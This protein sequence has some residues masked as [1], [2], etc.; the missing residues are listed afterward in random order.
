M[1]IEY[2]QYLTTIS[3]FIPLVF[4]IFVYKKMDSRLKLLFFYVCFSSAAS[5]ISQLIS[6]ADT[7]TMPEAHFYV[8]FE[9]I[10]LV[11]FYQ[12]YLTGYINKKY[13]WLIISGFFLLSIL[14]AL[15]FQGIDEYPN[16]PRGVESMV[17]VVFSVLYFHKVMVEAKI[18]NLAKEPMIWINTGM[19][20]YFSGD[21]FFH[22]SFPVVLDN[23]VDFA[24]RIVYFF[25]GMNILFYLMLTI[26]FYKQK[27]LAEQ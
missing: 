1:L 23:S 9:F 24:R 4:G 15:Y 19:L 3:P 26:G 14:N 6:I 7:T 25:W 27:K 21:F 10:I 18:K 17:M 16:I 11:L 13:I 2:Y 12:N 20:I 22:L 5:L 8:P